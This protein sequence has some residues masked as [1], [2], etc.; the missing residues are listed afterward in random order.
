MVDWYLMKKFCVSCS[1]CKARLDGRGLFARFSEAGLGVLDDCASARVYPAGQ[2]LFSEGDTPEGL[3]CLHKGLVKLYKISSD[4]KPGFLRLARPGYPLGYRAFFIDGVYNCTAVA[5]K[6]SEI[7]YLPKA[8]I[9]GLTES[10]PSLGK[11]LLKT[12]A[13]DLAGAEKNWLEMAQRPVLS[14]VCRLLLELES[15]ETWPPR[16]EMALMLSITPEVFA[17]TLSTLQAKGYLKRSRRKIIL[18]DREALGALAEGEK[19]TQD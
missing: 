18:L 16:G 17:R 7:C 13:D 11:A 19:L 9:S 12:L 15:L 14:R 8:S 4:G 5:M 10:E 3:H 2:T 6:E 1:S